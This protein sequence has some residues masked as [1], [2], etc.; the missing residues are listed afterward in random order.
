MNLGH[1]TRCDAILLI[2]KFSGM[3]EKVQDQFP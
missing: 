2:K 1:V 3:T